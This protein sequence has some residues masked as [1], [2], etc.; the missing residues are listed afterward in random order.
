MRYVP[1]GKAA[2]MLGVCVSTLRR[3]DAEGKLV[4][5]RTPSGRRRCKACDVATYNQLGLPS[6]TLERKTV[7]YARVS[8]HDHKADLVRQIKVLQMY[9]ASYGWAYEVEVVIIDAGDERTYK[10]ELA[11]DVLEISTVF[12]A[13]MY[14]ARSHKSK[15][16]VDGVGAVVKREVG[17]VSRS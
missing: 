12:S 1:I 13:R 17:D 6:P 14:G 4:A 9:C 3:G 8:F 7:A 11:W 15:P 16:L 5:E 2:E 10:E